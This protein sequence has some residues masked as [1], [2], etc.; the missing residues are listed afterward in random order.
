MTETPVDSQVAP[1]PNIRDAAKVYAQWM[2][3]RGGI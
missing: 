3:D 2:N 1:Y